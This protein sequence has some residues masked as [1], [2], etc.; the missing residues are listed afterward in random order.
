MNGPDLDAINLIAMSDAVNKLE[1]SINVY[2]AARSMQ[3]NEAGPCIVRFSVVESEYENALKKLHKLDRETIDYELQ[4]SIVDRL[5]KIKANLEELKDKLAKKY[6]DSL[7]KAYNDC[8]AAVQVYN[9]CQKFPRSP[10][11][12]YSDKF[13]MLQG[14]F[15]RITQNDDYHELMRNGEKLTETCT[16]RVIAE[17]TSAPSDDV[18]ALRQQIETQRQELSLKEVECTERECQLKEMQARLDRSVRAN[19]AL[20]NDINRRRYNTAT[21][22]SSTT[23]TDLKG[24]DVFSRPEVEER[25]SAIKSAF[26][27][28]EEMVQRSEPAATATEEQRASHTG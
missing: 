20:V 3:I 2:W 16:S 4:K 9:D 14:R 11:S 27:K 25:V 18:E 17:T 21:P 15:R 22:A 28:L 7:L 8:K 10:Y 1:D 13:N 23:Q 26:F 19:K 24:D 12:D 5:N 6:S